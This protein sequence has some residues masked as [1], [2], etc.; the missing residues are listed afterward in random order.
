M[1]LDLADDGTR[2]FLLA[3]YVGA[4]IHVPPPPP[5]QIVLVTSENP[6]EFEVMFEAVAVTG[7]M[8]VEPI[9]S[10]LAEVGYQIRAMRIEPFDPE[11]DGEAWRRTG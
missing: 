6:Y 4:C 5:N 1:P 7:E 3:P 11:S 9:S 2:T 10:R 8:R